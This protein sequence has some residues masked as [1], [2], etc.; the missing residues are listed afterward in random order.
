M[1]VSFARRAVAA[2]IAVVAVGV[3]AAPA[4][5]KVR[6]E[7]GYRN[8]TKAERAQM[9]SLN[10]GMTGLR[11]FFVGKKDPTYGYVCGHANGGK[12]GEGVKLIGGR[13]QRTPN[14]SSGM[15]QSYALYCGAYGKRNG[16]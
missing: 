15:L 13:W 11:G 12:W 14:P 10:L 1:T 4:S 3:S 9:R 8:A 2:L 5:A 7:P 6:P 16:A